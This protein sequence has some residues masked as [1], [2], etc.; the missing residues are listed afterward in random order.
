MKDL[1]GDLMRR[2]LAIWFPEPDNDRHKN[3]KRAMSPVLL[4]LF[5]E[6]S[7]H[8]RRFFFIVHIIPKLS[9]AF[10]FRNTNRICT[11]KD[12]IRILQGDFR[13]Y[14]CVTQEQM[15]VLRPRYGE[16]G[17]FLTACQVMPTKPSRS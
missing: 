7:G 2:I 14:D 17:R 16:M 6:D 12:M 15:D 1:F 4:C 10:M 3:E 5:C 8:L 13:L 11:Y 9:C